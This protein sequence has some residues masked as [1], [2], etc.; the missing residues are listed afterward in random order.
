M[1][2]Q[3]LLKM[4]VNKSF[5]LYGGRPQPTRDFV[6]LLTDDPFKSSFETRQGKRVQA[7]ENTAKMHLI[8]KKSKHE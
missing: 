5:D 7:V 1:A 3:Q 2:A 8:R 6:D 4:S